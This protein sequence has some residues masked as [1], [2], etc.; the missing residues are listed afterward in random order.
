AEQRPLVRPGHPRPDDAARGRR[1]YVPAYTAAAAAAPRAAVH[2]FTGSRPGAATARGGRPPAAA[3]T[4][5]DER[6]LG[7][8]ETG[9]GGRGA[10]S[11]ISP[12]SPG[13]RGGRQSPPHWRVGLTLPRRAS[14]GK[15]TP[16]P[17]APLPHRGEGSKRGRRALAFAGGTFII[18]VDEEGK[19]PPPLIH[20][21]R[22]PE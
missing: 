16:S 5:P 20:P 10:V 14:E 12:L 2:R 7:C 13:G 8:G 19:R 18:P 3:P 17:P 21:G 11:G 1:Q 15:P 22:A 4:I 6:A 9:G